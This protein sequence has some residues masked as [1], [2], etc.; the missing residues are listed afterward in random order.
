[1]RY[2]AVVHIDDDALLF[3]DADESDDDT[4]PHD[5]PGVKGIPRDERRRRK[6]T[7]AAAMKLQCLRRDGCVA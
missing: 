4:T 2:R 1:M 6:A 3:S 5:C 7:T